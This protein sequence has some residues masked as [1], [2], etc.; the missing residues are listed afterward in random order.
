[1]QRSNDGGCRRPV[2]PHRLPIKAAQHLLQ[3]ASWKRRFNALLLLLLL[4]MLLLLHLL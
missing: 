4:L 1:M 3:Y 2:L